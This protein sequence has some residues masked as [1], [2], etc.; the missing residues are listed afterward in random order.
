MSEDHVVEDQGEAT[1]FLA[2]PASHG[3]HDVARIDTHGAMVFLAGDRAYKIKRAVA[4]PYMDFSTLA[5][6]H[7]ACRAEVRLNR[8]TAPDFYLG[9]VPI[10][11]GPDGRLRFG[12][13]RRGDR[14]K[15]VEWAVVMRRF[16]QSSMLDR[17][18]RDGAL[19]PSIV[20]DLARVVAA[21]HRD[22]EP[23]RDF[24]AAERVPAVVAENFEELSREPALFAPRRLARLK[25]LTEAALAR[26]R[27]LL[28]ER[29]RAGLV[30]QCHGDLHLRNVCLIEGRPMLFDAIEFNDDFAVI[31]VLYDLAF[32]LMDLDHRGL[33]ELANVL[34]NQYLTETLDDAGLAALPLFLSMRAAVRAKVAVSVAAVQ[35]EARAAG[36]WR[37]EAR[38]FFERALAYVA[39][40]A[41][42]LIAIGGLS[43]TGKSTLARRLAPGFAPAPGA[44][45]L[46][47][48]VIR[49]RLAG[50]SETARLPADAY[51]PRMTRRVYG[52]IGRRA[53]TVLGAGY[54]VV[55]DAVFAGPQ[56]RAE[57]ER[58]ARDADV[59]F[60]GL[61]LHADA[62]TLLGRIG[63]RTGDASDATTEVVRR[64]LGYDLGRVTW[65]KVAAGDG[66]AE[67]AAAARER[68]GGESGQGIGDSAATRR[69][70]GSR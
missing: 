52:E 45:I 13:P 43:G 64:Q 44:I 33:T 69:A 65:P 68:L 66:P 11:R 70:T 26:T 9:V 32:L 41:P 47:S 1:R 18:A 4:F 10:V 14:A 61:W 12:R 37:R 38:R 17:M 53:A 51:R 55:A 22:A 63:A 23:R 5:R 35:S 2:D 24:G 60:D 39:A 40:P 15:A 7:A 31:D 36:E 21:F 48:D 8:R 58:V 19:T 67:V 59:R 34:I 54:P 27:S 3:G 49:K 42:R 56:E 50:V 28:R 57:I 62:E 46:R 20:S 16:E 6:R 25:R 30:R 29:E